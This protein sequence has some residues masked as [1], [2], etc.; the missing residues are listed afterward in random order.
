MTIA[1]NNSNNKSN[2]KSPSPFSETYFHGTKSDLKIFDFI[3]VGFDSHY[4]KS[5]R[6]FTFQRPHRN[7]ILV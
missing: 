7:L 2:K 6:R 4:K 3:E 1:T 5:G